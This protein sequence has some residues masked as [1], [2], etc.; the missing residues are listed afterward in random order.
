MPACGFSLGLERILL[1]MEERDM[2]P[3]HLD[4]QPQV[5]VTQFDDSHRGRQLAAGPRTAA[6]RSAGGSLSRE[7]QARQ[8][9]QVRR[10]AQ[11]PLSPSCW[12]Q[13]K[14]RRATP[15]SRSGQ[16]RAGGCAGG[17]SGCF[18]D[19][20]GVDLTQWRKGHE[21]CSI[22]DSHFQSDCHLLCSEFFKGENRWLS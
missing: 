3:E 11:Y 17:R 22:G 4:G 12:A 10:R 19:R 20:A 7:D 8:A 9:A 18:V 15:P 2:F 1:V 21:G 16:R 6:G 13:E 5:L 14:W